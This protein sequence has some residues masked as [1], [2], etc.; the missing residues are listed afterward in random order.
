V[1]G[2]SCKRELGAFAFAQFS[3]SPQQKA[4]RTTDTMSY[5]ICKVPSVPI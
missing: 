1:L 4:P 3:L 2:T 5:S